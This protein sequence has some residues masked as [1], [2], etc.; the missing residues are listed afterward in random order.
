MN[1]FKTFIFIIGAFSVTQE[2]YGTEDEIQEVQGKIDVKQLGREL[3]N[4]VTTHMDSVFKSGYPGYQTKHPTVFKDAIIVDIKFSPDPE[5][6]NKLREEI[7]HLSFQDLSQLESAL[8]LQKQDNTEVVEKFWDDVFYATSE[9]IKNNVEEQLEPPQENSNQIR[10]Q[11]SP[12]PSEQ[13]TQ[14]EKK[15][16][17]KVKKHIDSVLTSSLNKTL[18]KMMIVDLKFSTEP[19]LREEIENLSIRDL[20]RL[21]TRLY[22]Q[23]VNNQ[24]VVQ[25]FWLDVLDTLKK[26]KKGKLENYKL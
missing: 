7:E 20:M 12:T 23:I 26:I 16:V 22:Y 8:K 13:Q 24:K 2:I 9:I 17:N 11:D 18:E 6:P 21:H 3:V 4:K 19:T 15:L 25:K 5:K 14:L 1:I 10:S